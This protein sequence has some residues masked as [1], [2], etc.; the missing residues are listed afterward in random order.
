MAVTPAAEARAAALFAAFVEGRLGDLA[1]ALA[2]EPEEVAALLRRALRGAGRLGAELGPGLRGMAPAPGRVIGDFR[3]LRPL[4]RGGMGVVWEAEQMS[5]RRPVALKLLGLE[6]MALPQRVARFRREAEAGARLNHRHIVAVHAYGSGEEFHYLAQ[7]LIPGGRTLADELAQLRRAPAAPDGYYEEV[8]VRF[9]AVAEA[10]EYAHGQGV[11]HR[12]LKPSNLLVAEDG[13]LKVGDFG[14][15]RL[16]DHPGLS[17]SGELS[18][19]PYYMSPEQAAGRAGAVGPASDVFSLGVTLYEALTLTRPFDGDASAEVLAKIRL[20]EPPDPRARRARVPRELALIC[21]HAL[22]KEP[23]HRYPSMAALA[24]DLRRFLAH[25]P[26]LA[27]PPGLLRR[28]FQWSRRHP[29]IAA[30]GSVA[31]LAFVAVSALLAA[32]ARARR[33]A[34]QSALRAQDEAETAR[35][36]ANVLEDLLMSATPGRLPA[37]FSAADLMARGVEVVEQL[38]DQ[39]RVYLRLLS[40]LSHVYWSMGQS[41]PAEDLAQRQQAAA[42]A[43]GTASAE[44]GQALLDLAHVREMQSRYPEASAL[45]AEALEVFRHSVGRADRRYA[46]AGNFLGQ[47]LC[48]QGR[49][50]EAERVLRA[51][52]A[53]PAAELPPEWIEWSVARSSLAT[54]LFE[55]GSMVEAEPLL[56]AA[57]AAGAPRRFRDE[58]YFMSIRHELAMLR[59]RQGRVEEGLPDLESVAEW[60]GRALGAEAPATLATAADLAAAYGTAGRIEECRRGYEQALAEHERVLGRAHRETL[61]VRVNFASH[62]LTQ[63]DLARAG[64]LQAGLAE[65]AVAAYGED[66]SMYGQVRL[67]TTYLA[68]LER[69]EEGLRQLEDLVPRLRAQF[70]AAH[71][72]TLQAHNLLAYEYVDRGR[73]AEAEAVIRGIYDEVLAARGA[74]DRFVHLLREQLAELRIPAE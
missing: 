49:D 10:L 30:S 32:N 36:V 2:G 23:R 34:E 46:Q 7:E 18:G 72:L 62:C 9:A 4:G 64:E 51:L 44:Y 29:V 69:P 45:A 5:L 68:L 33:A 57:L 12:D 50:Q 60:R 71:E 43:L 48:L 53:A 3:L 15:A 65:L 1:A 61:R 17:R 19:T 58:E 52:V 24:A 54:L 25:E 13:A 22:E 70:G 31:A 47:A 20:E 38:E 14:L 63:D 37:E 55:R 35:E 42:A 39:P 6:Q 16:A 73:T 21:R 74:D 28:A 11:L 41:E 56:V 67:Q 8:A 27:R 66:S 26:I 40:T 59:V